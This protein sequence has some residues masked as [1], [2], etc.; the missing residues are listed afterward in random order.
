MSAQYFVEVFHA[1][2]DPR[3]SQLQASIA[4]EVTALGVHRSV[5]ITVTT[6]PVAAGPVVGVYFGSPES[7]AD[8]ALCERLEA[9]VAAGELIVPVVWS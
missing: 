2:Q 8:A 9:A 5:R 6:A 4:K 1:V 3:L 7:T